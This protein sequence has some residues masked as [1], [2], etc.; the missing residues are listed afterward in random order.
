M[1][2]GVQEKA[3]AAFHEIFADTLTSR[4]GNGIEMRAVIASAP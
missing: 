2:T 4:A 1:A 3:C